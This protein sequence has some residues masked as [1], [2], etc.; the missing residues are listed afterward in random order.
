MAAVAPSLP[1]VGLPTSSPAAGDASEASQSLDAGPST[2][3]ASEPAA[4]PSWAQF[5]PKASGP[6]ATPSWA[7]FAVD[8]LQLQPA[9]TVPETML[10][11][12]ALHEAALRDFT[13]LVRLQALQDLLLCCR[14][15]IGYLLRRV[16]IDDQPVT[17]ASRALVGYLDVRSIDSATAPSATVGSAMRRFQRQRPYQGAPAALWRC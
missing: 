11:A 15:A 2:P 16:L 10:L 4:T 1:A 5:T 9:L 6:A 3:K 12:Q 17:S 7:Q 13:I 14:M 8:D